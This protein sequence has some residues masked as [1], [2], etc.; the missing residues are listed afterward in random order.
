MAAT[1]KR[2]AQGVL[3]N[4]FVVSKKSK[5]NSTMPSVQEA[6]GEAETQSSHEAFSDTSQQ[7]E[8]QSSNEA[9]SVEKS[10]GANVSKAIA[11]DVMLLEIEKCG[12][13][14]L[15]NYYECKQKC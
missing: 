2:S 14:N 15:H 3:D 5:D 1:N 13:S 7:V 12:L 10:R 11:D 6:T 8:M 9:V 4:F